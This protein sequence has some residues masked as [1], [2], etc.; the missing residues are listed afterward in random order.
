MNVTG[1]KMHNIIAR[2]IVQSISQ[3]AAKVSQAC[4]STPANRGYNLPMDDSF[5]RCNPNSV[6]IPIPRWS[7]FCPVAKSEGFSGA[8]IQAECLKID[9]DGN[10]RVGLAAHPKEWFGMLAHLGDVLHFVRNDAVAL[11]IFGPIPPMENW[12][13]PIF[14]RDQ[15]FLFAQTWQSIPA[16]ARHAALHPSE[17]FINLSREMSPDLYSRKS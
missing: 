11:T 6:G 4:G 17:R 10:V 15:N 14:P 2:T 3:L 16:F 8:R 9:A 12:H 13:N 5:F 1:N 7:L